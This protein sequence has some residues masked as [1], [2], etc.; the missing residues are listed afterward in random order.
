[1]QPL[2]QRDYFSDHAIAKDPYRFYEAVRAHGPIWQPPN[3]DYLIVTGFQECL[4]V[5]NN[6]QDSTLR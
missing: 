2:E 1:M 6:H 5:L 3:R 4:E